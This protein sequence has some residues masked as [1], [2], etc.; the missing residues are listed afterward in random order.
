MSAQGVWHTTR[1]A[2]GSST[3]Q[4]EAGVCA[5]APL[6]FQ[7]RAQSITR[8]CVAVRFA[9]PTVTPIMRIVNILSQLRQAA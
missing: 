6:A 9:R 2:H 8:H 1:R 5:W 4:P 7:A 3:E